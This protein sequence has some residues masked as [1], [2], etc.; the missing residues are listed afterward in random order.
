MLDDSGRQFAT[1]VEEREEPYYPHFAYLLKGIEQMIH[2]GKPSYPV[3]RTMLTAGGL[4]HLLVSHREGGRRIDTED[5][6]IAYQP[7]DYPYAPGLDL[8]QE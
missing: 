1:R 2:T 3:E 8:G 5:L 7:V 4:D 6:R